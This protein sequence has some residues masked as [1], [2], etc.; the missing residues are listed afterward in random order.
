MNSS[1]NNETCSLCDAP[2]IGWGNNPFPLCDID[3]EVSRCCDTCNTAVIQARVLAFRKKCESPEEARALFK[4][5]D[6]KWAAV[7]TKR[8]EPVDEEDDDTLDDEDGDDGCYEVYSE[9]TWDGPELPTLAGGHYYQCWGGGPVGGFVVKDGVTYQV[10]YTPSTGWEM[11]KKDGD[12][13]GPFIKD[14][15]K[16]VRYP[17]FIRAATMTKRPEPE[18]K[19]EPPTLE[20]IEAK[21]MK[22]LLEK[23]F[24]HYKAR[25]ECFIDVVTAFNTIHDYNMEQRNE[26]II[27]LVVPTIRGS[28]M[29]DADFDFWTNKPI[30]LLQHLWHTRAED[31]HRII[32]TIKPIDSYDGVADNTMWDEV[33]GYKA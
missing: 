6:R 20:Q 19:A 8:P 25:A 12:L 10:N 15:V 4:G 27:P 11:E 13:V 9:D 16:Q 26:G 32:Q 5:K 30:R 22:Q 18:A 1:S 14:A 33:E 7:M 2:A 21:S 29:G 17:D 3:D 28:V 23:G 24:I 31:L